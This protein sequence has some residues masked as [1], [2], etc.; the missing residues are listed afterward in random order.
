[1]ETV[2][3][4][5]TEGAGSRP[6]WLVPGVDLVDEDPW[7]WWVGIGGVA[8]AGDGEFSTSTREDCCGGGADAWGDG[9]LRA[10][11][12]VKDHAALRAKSAAALMYDAMET[13]LLFG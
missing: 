5:A 12:G 7:T 8:G 4:R 2:G 10:T 1:M 11:D 13:P 9:D 6:K 3:E